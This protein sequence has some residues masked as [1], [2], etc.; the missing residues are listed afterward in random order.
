MPVA[1]CSPWPGMA[2]SPVRECSPSFQ[3]SPVGSGYG[4]IPSP[5]S[6]Q[7]MDGH[8][9]PPSLAMID[10]YLPRMDAPLGGGGGRR[11]LLF[12]IGL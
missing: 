2:D 4:P 10:Q 8:G 11:T 9:P 5:T 3:A 1:A 6:S 7:M 12:C